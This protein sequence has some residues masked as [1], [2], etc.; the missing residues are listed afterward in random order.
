MEF[1]NGTSSEVNNEVASLGANVLTLNIQSNSDVT[2][3]Y[4]RVR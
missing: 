2:L 3:D 4:S 1:G